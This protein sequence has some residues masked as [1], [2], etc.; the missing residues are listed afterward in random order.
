MDW[1]GLLVYITRTVDQELLLHSEYFVAENRILK[2][3][4]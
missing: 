4:I 1:A 2:T 3:Q